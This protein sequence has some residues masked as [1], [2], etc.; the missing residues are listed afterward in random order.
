M[1][2]LQPFRVKKEKEKEWAN[3][4]QVNRKSVA[5]SLMC[6]SIPKLQEKNLCRW[7]IWRRNH[8]QVASPLLCPACSGVPLNPRASQ[9]HMG[10]CSRGVE[11]LPGHTNSWAP[12]RRS[13]RNSGFICRAEPGLLGQD[14]WGCEMGSLG[15]TWCFRGRCLGSGWSLPTLLS[16]AQPDLQDPR[17]H[18]ATGSSAVIVEPF[19]L[20]LLS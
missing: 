15:L 16:P 7:H 3:T 9:P 11:S 13:W 4:L 14:T 5:R 19:F 20:L 12:F 10:V 8:N 1:E 2:Q 6:Q 18:R 17:I